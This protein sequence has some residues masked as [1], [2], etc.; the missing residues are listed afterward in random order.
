[1]TASYLVP[2]TNLCLRLDSVE[3]EQIRALL[4]EHI[5]DMHGESPPDSVH[6]FD[7]TRL[8]QPDIRFWSMWQ[9]DLL[10]ACGAWQRFDGTHGELKSMR[11]ASGYRRQGLAGVL[12][13]HLMH[14]A[15]T[16]GIT[17]MWLE[18][19]TTD[20]FSPAIALYHAHGFV[21]CAPFGAYQPDPYSRF[22]QKTL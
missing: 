18:T 2:D 14:D 11:T 3:G 7:F 17:S 19:G 4:R 13:R 6:A 15:K 21:D 12:L 8:Q 9:Q 5:R 16:H 22:M 10:L 20:Y 1:M